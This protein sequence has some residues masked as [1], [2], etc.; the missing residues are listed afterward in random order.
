MGEGNPQQYARA[1]PVGY[2]VFMCYNDADKTEARELAHSLQSTNVSVWFDEE[3]LRPGSLWKADLEQGLHGVDAGVIC[4]GANGI[5]PWQRIE[6]DAL[7]HRLVADHIPVI[8]IL[9]RSAPQKPNLPTFLNGLTWVDFRKAHPDP[10]KQLLW[11]I[12]GTRT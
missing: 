8:P 3:K 5:G 1:A 7:L 9:L 10:M 12:T 11:G 2:R 6:I 4:V